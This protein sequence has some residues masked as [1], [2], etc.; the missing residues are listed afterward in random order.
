MPNYAQDVTGYFQDSRQFYHLTTD[1]QA[2]ILHANNFFQEKITGDRSHTNLRKLVIKEDVRNIVDV[3]LALQ[4]ESGKKVEIS[5]R[6]INAKNHFQKICWEV[7]VLQES[8]NSTRPV[9]QWLG[10]EEHQS[11]GVFE[12]MGKNLA[13]IREKFNAYNGSSTGLW[14]VEMRVPMPVDL[15]IDGA[16][17]FISEHAILTDCNE[18]TARILGYS[19]AREII[20]KPLRD[21]MSL[22][23]ERVSGYAAKF[24][25]NNFHINDVE[26]FQTDKAG[27]RLHLL[28]N[29][30]GVVENGQIN[31]IWGTV[32]NIT[33]L[34][35]AEQK[36]RESEQFYR[37]LINDSLDGLFIT[38]KEGQI[39][40]VSPSAERILGYR[41]DELKQLRLFDLVHPEDLPEANSVFEQGLKEELIFNFVNLRFKHKQGNYYWCMV[42][43]HSMLNNPNVKGVI[44]YFADNTSRKQAEDALIASEHLFRSLIETLNVG[45]QLTDAQGNM[46]LFNPTALDLLGLDEP[47][48]LGK[49][50]V[51]AYD[52][53]H[54]DGTP[55]PK[56]K[57]PITIALKDKV[58]V[59]N[60]VMGLKRKKQNDR[61]WL[62]VNSTPVFNDD[63]ELHLVISS[64]SDISEHRR[65]IMQLNEQEIIRQKHLLQVTI[66]AQEKERREIGRELHD[67]ISQHITITRLHLE[68]AKELAIGPLSE[69][70]NL[71]HKSLLGI[72]NEIRKLSHS[73]VPPSINDIGLTASIQDLCD[74]LV[75]SGEYIINFHSEGFDEDITPENMRLTIYRIIQE[76]VNNIIRHSGAKKIN[77]SLQ[78]VED[79][80]LLLIEDDG[81]GFDAKK[82]RK[83]LGLTNISNRAGLFGGRVSV[84]SQPGKGCVVEVEIPLL[85]Q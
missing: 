75:S 84:D 41:P 24:F 31:R 23:D 6:F 49:S 35:S 27:N 79:T 3:L 40:F 82:V 63:G 12:E 22:E 80:I 64:Y 13:E 47:D 9:L 11:A 73:L 25:A 4:N 70:I 67:N 58:P 85:G 71:A 32:H 17:V 56:E 54:E 61:V 72:V 78:M 42:R 53:I 51:V 15:S 62:I 43:A 37:N 21:V 36:L 52:I 5:L 45:V 68:V 55:F 10:I 33:L 57:Y 38:N 48:V 66:D 7:S 77:I 50:A 81:K 34:K 30:T 1:D 14:K 29:I 20:G 16:A 76:Q 2:N 65:L 69:A 39:I 26:I 74:S 60:V 46:I 8:E 59:K 28:H 19:N 83:G 18:S 44:I